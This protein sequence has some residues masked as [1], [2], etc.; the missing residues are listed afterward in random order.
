[1]EICQGFYQIKYVVRT[2][3]MIMTRFVTIKL[4]MG[5]GTF[6]RNLEL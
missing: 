5:G 4:I 2:R 1:M 6:I 3:R